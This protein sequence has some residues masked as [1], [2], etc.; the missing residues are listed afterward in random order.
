MCIILHYI[1]RHMAV[2]SNILLVR[3]VRAKV[4]FKTP[5]LYNI[6]I[7]VLEIEEKLGIDL[8]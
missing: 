7:F 2:I 1:T 4:S 3:A 5:G 6:D 8:A